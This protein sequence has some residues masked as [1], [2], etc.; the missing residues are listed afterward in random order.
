MRIT[1]ERMNQNNLQAEAQK[2]MELMREV[3]PH[4]LGEKLR[5]IDEATVLGGGRLPESRRPKSHK[6]WAAINR[7]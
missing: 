7:L 3:P 4:E 6:S 1:G 5:P 2:L